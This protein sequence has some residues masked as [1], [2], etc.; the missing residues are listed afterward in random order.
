M[1]WQ[2]EYPF[3][4]Q[5]RRDAYEEKNMEMQYMGNAFSSPLY[6]NVL[7]GGRKAYTGSSFYRANGYGRIKRESRAYG[8]CRK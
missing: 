4:F 5:N 1:N 7:L 3:P 8:L 2:K 6:D